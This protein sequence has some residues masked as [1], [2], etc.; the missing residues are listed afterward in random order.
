MDNKTVILFDRLQ[1]IESAFGRRHPYKFRFK[2][3]DKVAYLHA[4]SVGT[5]KASYQFKEVEI[6]ALGYGLLNIPRYHIKTLR[7]VSVSRGK[8]TPTKIRESQ[9]T[10][11][12]LRIDG[13]CFPVENWDNEIRKKVNLTNAMK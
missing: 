11:E 5:S 6:L 10:P 2:V 7:Q 9:T 12:A 4:K 3:G 13:D 8:M 1:P